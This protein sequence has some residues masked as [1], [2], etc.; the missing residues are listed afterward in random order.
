MTKR[1]K[2]GLILLTISVPMLWFGL[3]NFMSDTPSSNALGM[4]IAISITFGGL[5]AISGLVMLA[6]KNSLGIWDIDDK[7]KGRGEGL[8]VSQTTVKDPPIQKE[9]IKQPTKKVNKMAKTTSTSVEMMKREKELEARR[10]EL[11]GLLEEVRH[12]ETK[13]EQS[14]QEKG[15]VKKDGDWGIE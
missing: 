12:E 9:V 5:F 13:L 3:T 15:W 11:E 6:T 7:E 14:L 8:L 2:Q 1:K 10:K 4:M